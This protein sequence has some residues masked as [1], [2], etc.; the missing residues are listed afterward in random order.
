VTTELGRV[1]GLRVI[2]SN[3]A[4]G[5][6]NDKRFRDIGRRLEVG[7]LVRGSVQREGSAV[8]INVSL[9]DPTM[10]RRYGVSTTVER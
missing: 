1:G 6:R 3:T 2:A 7:M 9:I 4:F 8:R 10:T 5:Y